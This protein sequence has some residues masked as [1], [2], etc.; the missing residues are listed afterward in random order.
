MLDESEAELIAR[1]RLDGESIPACAA[2]SGMST[3]QLYRKRAQAEQR[4]A[5][6]LR[7]HAF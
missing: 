3:R 2:Q 5:N 7:Q 6:A 4:L 1:T